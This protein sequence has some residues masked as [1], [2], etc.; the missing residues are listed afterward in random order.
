MLRSGLTRRLVTAAIAATLVLSCGAAAPVTSPPA[1]GRTPVSPT[2]PV[3]ISP[4]PASTSSPAPVPL[5]SA[6]PAGAATAGRSAAASPL[7]SADPS[8]P[9]PPPD[10][11]VDAGTCSTVGV[12]S[13]VAVRIWSSVPYTPPVRCTAAG[14][15]CRLRMDVFAPV[16]AG[17]WPLV[18]MLPGGP[19][20]P[21]SYGYARQVGLSLAG[22]GAVVMVAGWR[23]APEYGGGY[24]GSF[25]D[26][27]CAIGVARM[28]GPSYGASRDHVVLAGHSLGGWAAA[29]IALTDTPYTPAAGSCN[30]TS[31]SL[32]P[33]ALVTLN[34]S[35]TEVV[36]WKTNV[37]RVTAF[38]GGDRAARP[39]A[40]AASDPYALARSHPASAGHVAITIVQGEADTT[41]EPDVAREF[42]AVLEAAGLESRLVLVPKAG[43][44][45]LLAAGGAIEAIIQAA[46]EP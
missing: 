31:G 42:H 36:A 40:W 38:L 14:A 17:G 28:T 5:A 20:P 41:V 21:N 43:H 22:Q 18:V 9:L 3:P 11:V 37:E 23:Q 27:A 7:A 13:T 34:G 12:C 44:V 30:A 35:V 25:R 39:D 26:I 10:T 16:R 32:R 24:P 15:T 29:V 46:R 1:G 19:Q 33:D 45:D 4:V 6:S 8:V 2:G